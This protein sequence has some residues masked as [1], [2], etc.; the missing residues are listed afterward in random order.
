MKNSTTKGTTKSTKSKAKTT[1]SKKSG[2]CC[3]KSSAQESESDPFGS[4]TGNPVGW[5]IDEP[6]V[7]D[8][9]DL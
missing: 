3:N 7:Q 2:G 5:G 4:Y 8:A 1:G 6:P 9:D